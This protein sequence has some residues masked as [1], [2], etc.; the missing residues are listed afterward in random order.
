MT[1]QDKL[2]ALRA[3]A[4]ERLPAEALAAMQRA[5]EDLRASGI[6]ERVLGPGAAAPDFELGNVRGETVSSRRLLGQGPLV[7]TFYRGFW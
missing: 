3:G 2:D 7:V 1:L 4:K 6:M 5:T